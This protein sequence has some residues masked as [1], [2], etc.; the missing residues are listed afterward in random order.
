MTMIL[1]FGIL[2]SSP[3]KFMFGCKKHGIEREGHKDDV[4]KEKRRRR[5]SSS[6]LPTFQSLSSKGGVP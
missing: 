6:H 2:I 3:M 4:S 1:D 5:R